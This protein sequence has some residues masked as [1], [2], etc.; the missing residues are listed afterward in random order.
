MRRFLLYIFFFFSLLVFCSIWI[1]PG[2]IPWAGIVTLLIPVMMGLNAFLFLYLLFKWKKTILFP[3]IILVIAWGFWTRTIT[4]HQFQNED[5]SF[6]LLSYNVRVFNV[7]KH[8]NSG[9]LNK[10]DS[11][12][13]WVAK[14]D[15][16]IKCFQEFYNEE[17]SEYWN[18]RERMEREG[19]R[20]HHIHEAARNRIG[21]Q[22][23]QAIFSKFPIVN[24]D[25]LIKE[26]GEEFNNM[27]YADV[28]ING[29]TLRVY[30]LHLESMSINENDVVSADKLKNTYKSVIKRLRAGSD[31]R[32]KQIERLVEHIGL[33]PHRVIV[34]GDFND[35]PYSYS[36]QRLNQLLENSFQK[37]GRGFGF[38]FNGKLF[39]LRIDNQFFGEGVHIHGFK[40][41]REVDFSDHFPIKAWYSI[42]E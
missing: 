30:S 17:G 32:S 11:M 18:I 36:Y 27:I 20:Y 26:K 1:S 4:F 2:W 22:F 5:A 37:K 42:A 21:A 38:S 34:A 19:Y 10:V 39:F 33:S 8:L 15:S 24:Q 3:A 16:D 29:D 14:E 28:L 13:Q 40:T 6:S 23:G 41:L 12:M 7:Y 9:D 31:K 35:L 25:V